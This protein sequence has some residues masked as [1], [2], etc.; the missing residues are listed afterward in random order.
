MM[1]SHQKHNFVLIIGKAEKDISLF[2]K[3]MAIFRQLKEIITK[4]LNREKLSGFYKAYHSYK[5]DG[6]IEY[7]IRCMVLSWKLN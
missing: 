6:S 4:H 2:L 5:G 1:F 3:T 7:G